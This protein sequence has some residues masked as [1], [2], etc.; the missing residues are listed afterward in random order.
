MLLELLHAKSGMV[1]DILLECFSYFIFLS[2]V[3]FTYL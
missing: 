3:F 1:I 2:S